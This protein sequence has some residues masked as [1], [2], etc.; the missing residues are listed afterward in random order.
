MTVFLLLN[1]TRKTLKTKDYAISNQSRYEEVS[2][3]CIDW[4]L[5]P[6][7]V[8]ETLAESHYHLDR[9]TCQIDFD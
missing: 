1:G 9:G 6:L 3:L 8:T 2:L 7:L 4:L 5:L